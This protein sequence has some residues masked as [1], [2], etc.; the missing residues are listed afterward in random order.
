M[1]TNTHFGAYL[2]QFFWEGETF[3]IKVVE[4]IERHFMF[5]NFFSKI[6]QFMR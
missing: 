4:K 5:N 1:E 2:A 6:V 3:L